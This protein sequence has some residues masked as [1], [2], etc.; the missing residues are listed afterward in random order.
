MYAHHSHRSVPGMGLAFLASS[1]HAKTCPRLSYKRHVGT[2]R[3][4]SNEP[5]QCR[6]CWIAPDAMRADAYAFL[7]FQ[8]QNQPTPVCTFYSPRRKR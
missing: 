3:K 2:L 5:G 4:V 8:I 6:I 7:R 1:P